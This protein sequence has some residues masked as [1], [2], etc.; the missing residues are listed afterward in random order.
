MENPIPK[1]TLDDIVFKDRNKDYGAYFM[2]KGYPSDLLFS[3]GISVGFC[4]LMLYLFIEATKLG[5]YDSYLFPLQ[6]GKSVNVELAE[7]PFGLKTYKP[8]GKATTTT[9]TVPKIVAVLSEENKDASKTEKDSNGSNDSTIKDNSGADIKDEGTSPNKGNGIVGEIY[10]SADINPQFPGGIKAMQEY[11]KD[12]LQYPE[13]ARRQNIRG[14]IL[15]YVVVASDGYLRD[16]KVVKGLQTDLDNE[17]VRM[18]NSMPRWKPATRGG[19]PVNVR[20]TL[21]ISVSP[22]K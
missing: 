7:K 14:T 13:I 20:C 22:L 11:I 19:I 12:S 4:F 6:E 15:I 1:P 18:V 16:V 9:F 5:L 17:A 8:V 3:L 21:P 2:R 10:G